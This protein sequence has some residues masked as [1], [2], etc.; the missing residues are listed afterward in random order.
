[1]KKRIKKRFE[2]ILVKKG[3]RSGMA[4][5]VCAI[6]LAMSLGTLVGCS[7]TPGSP[8]ALPDSS[9]TFSASAAPDSAGVPNRSGAAG[10]VMIS[11]SSGAENTQAGSAQSG[12][13]LQGTPDAAP[14]ATA[15]VPG[16]GCSDP[17]CTD[18]AH[19]HDCPAGCADYEHHHTC[20]LDCTDA[21]HHHG[22]AASN[23]SGN[24]GSS[25]SA[26]GLDNSGSSGSSGG[27][28]NESG[29]HSDRHHG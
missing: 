14:I 6:V 7:I 5:F 11:G 27:H 22:M 17:A 8:A 23:N 25:G 16:M 29:H 4:V 9:D 20:A 19:H 28:H 15:F 21:S 2:N 1:M 18:A 26:G 3:K 10:S 24:M 12:L 13:P